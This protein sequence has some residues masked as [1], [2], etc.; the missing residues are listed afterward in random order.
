VKRC[1]SIFFAGVGLIAIP[2]IG[3]AADTK[4][5]R[6][7]SAESQAV[8]APKHTAPGANAI[9]R[10]CRD[11]TFVDTVSGHEAPCRDHGGVATTLD[12][13]RTTGEPR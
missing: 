5:P 11:G 3:F 6:R 4:L 12:K 9:D 13:D 10:Q 7:D 8:P 1:L 2:R